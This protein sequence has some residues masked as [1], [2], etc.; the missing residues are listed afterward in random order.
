MQFQFATKAVYE[1]KKGNKVEKE[2]RFFDA[3]GKPIPEDER[4]NVGNGTIGRIR[5]TAR[6][7]WI[8]ATGRAGVALYL[9]AIKILTLVEY[10]GNLDMGEEEEGYIHEA[11]ED[12]GMGGDES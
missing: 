4:P 10:Q 1:D 2:V 3:A 12:N 9:E 11:A 7:Y 5:F 8:P 6:P